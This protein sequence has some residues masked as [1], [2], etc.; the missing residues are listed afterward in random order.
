[1]VEGLLDKIEEISS[2]I[3]KCSSSIPANKDT[4]GKCY[5]NLDS[6]CWT[7]NKHSCFSGGAPLLSFAQISCYLTIRDRR[8]KHWRAMCSSNKTSY[9]CCHTSTEYGPT[10]GSSYCSYSDPSHTFQ[11]H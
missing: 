2:S 7:L 10:R 4:L 11:T 9:K 5:S 1:M 8:L 6:C 3:N